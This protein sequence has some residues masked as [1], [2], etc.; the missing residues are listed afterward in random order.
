MNRSRDL[1]FESV[2]NIRDLGGILSKDGRK[3]KDRLLIRSSEL[4]RLDEEEAKILYEDIG[5]KTVF[6]FRSRYEAMRAPDVI[7]EGVRL[8]PNEIATNESFGVRRDEET[9]KELDRIM[10]QLRES[11]DEELALEFMRH[12]YRSFA[13]SDFS[14]RQYGKFL[15]YVLDHEDP[16]LWHCSMGKDRCGVGTV[17]VL[18]LLGVDREDIIEDYLYTNEIYG[19]K[20]TGYASG[21]EIADRSYIA[22]FYDEVFKAYGDLASFFEQMNISERDRV[23]FRERVLV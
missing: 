2:A 10:K 6:D 1:Q 4:S 22:A 13:I 23:L 3:I 17:L 8:I 20:D 12:F 14:L 15:H 19:I 21:F 18:E 7:G 9:M 5:V 11:D 16:V